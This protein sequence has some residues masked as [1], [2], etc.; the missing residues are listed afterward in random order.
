MLKTKSANVAVCP[1]IEGMRIEDLV[2]FCKEHGIDEYLPG[3]TRGGK[4][5]H[6]D[7]DYLL[8][9]SQIDPIILF[10]NLDSEYF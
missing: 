6:Y 4:A 7:R 3:P 5:P 10:N 1:Q 9:V 8:T 2:S